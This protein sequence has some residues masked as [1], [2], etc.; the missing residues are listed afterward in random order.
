MIHYRG[1]CLY[2]EEKGKKILAVGDLHL[3]YEEALNKHGVFVL[4]TQ[5]KE[6][7]SELERIFEGLGMVDK[8]VLLGDVKHEFG[9]ILKQERTDLLKLLDY[10]KEHAREVIIVRGNHDAV[11]EFIARDRGIKI[12]DFYISD[13]YCFLHGDKDFEEIHDRKIT[14]WIVGHVHPAITLTEGVKSE[15]YKCFLE[16]EYKGR[17]VIVVP[18]FLDINEGSDPRE[19]T[20]P[21]AWDISFSRFR[22]KV[23][24]EDLSVLDFGRLKDI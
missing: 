12:L 15:K 5:F 22:V 11:L 24:G 2:I 17:T 18:S 19:G 9:A 3:G 1:K 4:R 6:M 8:V 21:L 23:V 10:L 13:G 16:G 14:H 7:L 20:I